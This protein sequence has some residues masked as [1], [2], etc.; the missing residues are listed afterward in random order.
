MKKELK[1]YEEIGNWDFDHIKRKTEKKTKWDY[2]EKIKENVSETS[3]C[4][5]IGTGG[6]EKVLKKYPDVGMIIATDF[7]DEMIKTAKKNQKEYPKKRVKFTKMDN[8]KMTFPKNTFDL[9]SAKHTVISAEQI[10]E[11]LVEGGTL[12]IEGVDQKDCWHLKEMF[13]RGQAFFDAV[14]ISK[15]DYDNLVKA[16]FKNIELVEINEDEYYETEEDLLALLLKTPI[17]DDFSETDENEN[18]D[19]S[20]VIEKEIFNEYVKRY[21]TEKGILLER[22]LYGIVAKK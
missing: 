20:K 22:V 1:F 5:D 12:V 10:Y 6:G 2:Y 9:I 11:L 19:H 15:I 7:S 3:L 14:P 13:K 17:L 16:G 18:F 4:L 21:K 8:L